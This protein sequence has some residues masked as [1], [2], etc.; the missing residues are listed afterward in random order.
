MSPRL[1]PTFAAL[2]LA[3]CAA[4]AQRLP[5]CDGQARRPA[6]PSGSVLAPTAVVSGPSSAPLPA[7]FAPCGDRP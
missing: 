3:G 4:S 2:A 5:V 1:L 7:S 6:N